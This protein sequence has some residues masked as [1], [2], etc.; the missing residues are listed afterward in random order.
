MNLQQALK[1]L[2][3]GEEHLT[4]NEKILVKFFQSQ[5]DNLA[6]ITLDEIAS[7]TFVSQATVVRLCKKLGYKGWR[8]FKVSIKQH[9]LHMDK[10]KL[11]RARENRLSQT[12]SYAR[13]VI[14]NFDDRDITKLAQLIVS[15]PHLY[16]YGREMSSIPAAYLQSMLTTIDVHCTLI[17]W[18]ETFKRSLVPADSLVIFCGT[19]LRDKDY[20]ELLVRLKDRNTTIVLISTL[21]PQVADLADL[22]IVAPDDF[23]T[24]SGYSK[25]G[26]FFFMH[27]LLEAVAAEQM[28]RL[29]S[30]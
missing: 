28:R 26:S 15:T 8:E 30:D 23:Q 14:N 20:R 7:A 1:A 18:L 9:S 16:I 2:Q 19:Y 22:T 24:N 13:H 5:G 6:H 21:D 3:T 12:T 11:V 17:D 25:L 10:S 27:L 4:N 29:Q